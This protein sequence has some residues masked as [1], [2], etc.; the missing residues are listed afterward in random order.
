MKRLLS[1]WLQADGWDVC[2]ALG[3]QPG[4]DVDARRGGERWVIEAK[5]ETAAPLLDFQTML[6]QVVCLLAAP[7]VRYSVALPDGA[8]YRALWA[9]VPELARER[10]GISAL[11]ISADGDVVEVA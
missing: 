5:G 7:E 4:I 2:V 1:A 6:G 9:R 10:L 11:F 8:A 3:R